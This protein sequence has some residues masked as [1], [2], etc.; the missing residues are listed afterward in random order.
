MERGLTNPL[1]SNWMS[2]LVNNVTSKLLNP[3]TIKIYGTSGLIKLSKSFYTE[4]RV[5][6]I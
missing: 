3:K 6:W 1:L 2:V 5:M 4:L